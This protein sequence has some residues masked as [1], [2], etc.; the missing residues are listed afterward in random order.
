MSGD[1]CPTQG[2]QHGSTTETVVH[3]R[4]QGRDSP[5]D[6]DVRKSIRQI[7]RDVDLTETA[8][9]RWVEQ[10]AIDR[11][12]RDGLTTS[13]REELGRLRREVRVLQEE[14]EIPKKGCGLLCQG[15]DPV[16]RFRFIAAEKAH[17][18]VARLCRVL[19]VSANG[20]YAWTK[21]P[22]SDRA[23]A[24]RALTARIRSVRQASRGIYGAPRI[25]AELRAQRS[26][27][28]RKRVARLM[29]ADG[30]AD[31]VSPMV[32]RISSPRPASQMPAQIRMH[33]IGVI[34]RKT[35]CPS[36]LP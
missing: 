3:A 14:R 17:N 2:V 7:C 25:H 5:V 21:R 23:R 1:T 10:A 15:D 20:F 22:P 13:E 36:F 16:S 27:V 18:P 33:A 28:A 24:D 26:R 29:R 11:G 32:R 34:L 6:P 4:V 12:E 8:V 19:Q 9:R 31:E 35:V 30:L